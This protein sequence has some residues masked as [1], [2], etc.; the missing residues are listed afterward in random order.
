VQ[1][2]NLYIMPDLEIICIASYSLRLSTQIV[3]VLVI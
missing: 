2:L 3:P 1:V